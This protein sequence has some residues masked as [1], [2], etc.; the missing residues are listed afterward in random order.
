MP[1]VKTNT[2][3][4]AVSAPD[5]FPVGTPVTANDPSSPTV[6]SAPDASPAMPSASA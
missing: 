5:G 2:N 6:V 1:D 3:P 4:S